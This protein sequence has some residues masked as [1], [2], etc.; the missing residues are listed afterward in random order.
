M[1][2]ELEW[3][4]CQELLHL[5]ISGRGLTSPAPRREI[6]KLGGVGKKATSHSNPSLLRNCQAKVMGEVA[7]R[8]QALQR[9]ATDWNPEVS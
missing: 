7:I 4:G 9:F 8:G 5:V 3:G 6:W 1:L 2:N